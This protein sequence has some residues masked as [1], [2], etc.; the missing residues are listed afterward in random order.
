M[1]DLERLQA[2]ETRAKELLEVKTEDLSEI[3]SDIAV[4]RY[5]GWDEALERLDHKEAC[6]MRQINLLR[7]VIDG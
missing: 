5:A 1:A 2:M 3:R 6:T 7:E 4:A